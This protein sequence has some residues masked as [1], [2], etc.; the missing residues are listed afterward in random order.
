M[1]VQT[2]PQ[3]LAKD[4]RKIKKTRISEARY[5]ELCQFIFATFAQDKN[6]NIDFIKALG[7]PP[8]QFFYVSE[9]KYH[10]FN[11]CNLWVNRGLSQIGV[12]T[13]LWS[14]LDK[15]IFYQFKE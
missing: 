14:P 4:S 2:H 6:Q 10:A 15:G 1:R 3:G 8:K 12:R 11:T 13:A 9:E 7:T 5:L